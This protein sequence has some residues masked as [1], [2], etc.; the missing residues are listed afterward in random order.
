M[1]PT[2]PPQL[3]PEGASTHT[4]PVRRKPDRVLLARYE[5]TRSRIRRCNVADGFDVLPSWTDRCGAIS[6]RARN[7]FFHAP[8]TGKR[9]NRRRAT[10]AG[11]SRRVR[12]DTGRT[13]TGHSGTR[14][15]T[16]P[17]GRFALSRGG[18]VRHEGALIVRVTRSPAGRVMRDDGKPQSEGA[19]ASP[20]ATARLAP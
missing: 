5:V 7:D 6:L 18:V 8:D 12:Q 9:T 3:G 17:N 13:A 10:A 15:R 1:P 20:S 11:P 4:P 19:W 14:Q 2:T 16:Q